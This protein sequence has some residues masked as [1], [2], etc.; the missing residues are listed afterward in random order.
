MNNKKNANANPDVANTYGIFHK[1]T[2]ERRILLDIKEVG[3]NVKANLERKIVMQVEGRC[4]PE[5]YVR[6]NSVRIISYTAG[7]LMGER[8][9][10]NIVYE[11][12]VSYPVENMI[13]DCVA[14]SV[15]DS[16]GVRAEVVME[17]G[18]VP[19]TVF[20]TRDHNYTNFNF[21]KVKEGDKIQARIIGITFEVNDPMIYATA[22]FLDPEKRKQ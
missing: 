4:I 16:A 15:T 8:I 3:R 22:Y 10:F 21:S 20:V 5:G 11:C 7:I 6:I 14:R 17:D 9:A 13:V 19:L 1:C 12:L 18:S 2:L